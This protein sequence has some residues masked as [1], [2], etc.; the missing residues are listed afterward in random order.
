MLVLLAGV[1]S[2]VALRSRPAPPAPRNDAMPMLGWAL[3]ACF[4]VNHVG[5]QITT[6]SAG[7]KEVTTRVQLAYLRPGLMRLQYLDGPLKGVKVWDD[8]H[9]IY[10]YHPDKDRMDVKPA[11]QCRPLDLEQRLALVR[12]NYTASLERDRKSVV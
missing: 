6:V 4:G 2:V 1:G 12:E 9:R 11:A 10:R 5:E 7:D 8:G 3:H